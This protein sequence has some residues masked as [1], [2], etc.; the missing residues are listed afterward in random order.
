MIMI[1][2]DLYRQ[3]FSRSQIVRLCML[4]RRVDH[5]EF[6]GIEDGVLSTEDVRRLEFYRFL[7]ERRLVPYES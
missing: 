7:R 6:G 1:A 5:G 4:R 2:R 3:G